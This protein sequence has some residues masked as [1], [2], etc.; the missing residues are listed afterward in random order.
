ME[1][2]GRK[3][4]EFK[5]RVVREWAGD[6]AAAAWQKH[7]AAMT[8]QMAGVTQTLVERARPR[9]GEAVLDLASGNGEP[10]LSLAMAVAPRGSV[11]ATDLSP[12]MLAALRENAME[13]GI[14]NI[15]THV[16]DAHEIPFPDGRFD[17]VSS[18]FGVMFFVDIDRALGEVRR[19]LKPGG[20]ITFLVWGAPSPGTYFGAAAVPYMRRLPVRPDPDAPAPMRFAEP[21]KLL[22]LVQ[23]AGFTDTEETVHMLPAPFIGPPEELLSQMFEIAAPFRNAAANLSDDDREA[24]EAEA[25]ENLRALFDGNAI[26]LS[27]PVLVVTGTKP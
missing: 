21:G 1:S 23:K 12:F 20:R 7:H 6:D 16:V 25:L 27:A 10:A 14:E 13:E 4:A 5:E 8:R 15:E 11:V 19:V 24:A 3:V 26:Q 2:L 18:R 17:L 9:P 22:A